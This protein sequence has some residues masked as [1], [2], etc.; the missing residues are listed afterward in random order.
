[1]SAKL[2]I[3]LLGVFLPADAL[4]ATFPNPPASIQDAELRTQQALD[5]L[6]HYYWKADPRHKKNQVFLRMFSTG[7][8]WNRQDWAVQL[9]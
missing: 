5:G 8:S 2:A 6:F 3:L 4:L 1:M 7:R 9:L